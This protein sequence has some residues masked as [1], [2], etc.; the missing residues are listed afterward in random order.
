MKQPAD[1]TGPKFQLQVRMVLPMPRSMLGDGCGTRKQRS[2]RA[3]SALCSLRRVFAR[4]APHATFTYPDHR[5]RFRARVREHA[6][7]GTDECELSARRGRVVH[8]SAHCAGPGDAC[9]IHYG[10]GPHHAASRSLGCGVP[11]ESCAPG[12]GSRYDRVGC[13]AWGV[14]PD[15][16][17]GTGV[18]PRATSR[19]RNRPPIPALRA[20]NGSA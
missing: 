10:N 18:Q 1:A 6:G 9:A 7:L 17:S 8:A 13:S 2:L 12:H 11:T 19:F 5:A 16:D 4:R 15:D 20:W 14:V 3:G